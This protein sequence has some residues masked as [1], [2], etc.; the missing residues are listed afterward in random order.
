MTDYDQE[1]HLDELLDSAL[2]AYSSA[3][4]RPGLETRILA[5]VREAAGTTGSPSRNWRWLWA[6]AVTV[7]AVLL[8]AL[9]MGKRTQVPT[10][11]NNVVRTHE[12]PAQ[13]TTK[14]ENSNPVTAANPAHHRHREHGERSPQAV[15]VAV[16]RQPVFPTPT[17]LSEQERLLLSYYAQTPRQEL[18]AQSHPDEPPQVGVENQSNI[19]VPEVIFVPQKS[20]NTR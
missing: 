5:Q 14:P 6:G 20:S 9:W 12:P 19:A 11:T 3:E 2:S 18:I 7:A 8:I 4:P 15:A 17:P 13:P 1:K 10:P 16:P